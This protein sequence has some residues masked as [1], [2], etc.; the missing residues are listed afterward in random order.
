MVVQDQGVF[1]EGQRISH[2]QGYAQMPSYSSDVEEALALVSGSCVGGA[3]SSV[4]T[5]SSL[6]HINCLEMMAGFLTLRY[7]L[8]ELRGSPCACPDRN[9]QGACGHAFLADWHTKSSCGPGQVALGEGNLSTSL[10]T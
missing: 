4:E 3:L 10:G 6:W 7:F 2:H 8:P 9:H 5:P 1:P